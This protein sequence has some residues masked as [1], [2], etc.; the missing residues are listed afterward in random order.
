MPQ[1]VGHIG[2]TELGIIGE[3]GVPVVSVGNKIVVCPLFTLM[4][5]VGCPQFLQKGKGG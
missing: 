2:E 5:T 1:R 3:Q 4:K